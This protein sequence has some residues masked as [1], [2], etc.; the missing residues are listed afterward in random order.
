MFTGTR[1]I[2]N[3]R[4]VREFRITEKLREALESNYI[5]ISENNTINILDHED[6]DNEILIPEIKETEQNNGE[7]PRKYN[8]RPRENRN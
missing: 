3:H 5:I 7:N 1:V 4:Y 8:L 2:R 6:I